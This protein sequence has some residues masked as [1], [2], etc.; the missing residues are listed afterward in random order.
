MAHLRCIEREPEDSSP[1]KG[2]AEI[3]AELAGLLETGDDG[4]I[5]MIDAALAHAAAHN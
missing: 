5:R 3:E 4:A 1:P 2:F